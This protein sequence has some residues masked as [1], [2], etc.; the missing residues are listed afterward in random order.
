MKTRLALCAFAGWLLAS[1]AFAQPLPVDYRSLVSRADIILDR[2]VSRPEGGMPIGNGPMGSLIWT[3]PHALKLQVNRVDVFGND[4][5]SNSFPQRYTDYAGA[6]A[7]VDIE[8]L[9][10]GDDVLTDRDTRQ[11]LHSADGM[12]DQIEQHRRCVTC[13]CS[14]SRGSR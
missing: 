2:P 5:S 9:Q 14:A 8:F 6:C 7:F 13:T 3:A 12:A 11:H 1:L 4:L 10:Y